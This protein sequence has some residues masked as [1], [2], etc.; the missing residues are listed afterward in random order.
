MAAA[1]ALLV[2]AAL[3][4]PAPVAAGRRRSGWIDA[5]AT[6]YGDETGAETMRK[7][8]RLHIVVVLVQINRD[9]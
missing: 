5:H 6:F 4:S 8:D 3:S 9:S 7:L 1:A 2:L